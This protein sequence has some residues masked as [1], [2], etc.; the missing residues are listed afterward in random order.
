MTIPLKMNS[1][2]SYFLAAP[3]NMKEIQ[4]TVAIRRIYI[5]CN[6]PDIL[7]SYSKAPLHETC[8]MNGFADVRYTGLYQFETGNQQVIKI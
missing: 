5:T 6:I 4:N 7:I 2:I 1:Q 8:L 3:K